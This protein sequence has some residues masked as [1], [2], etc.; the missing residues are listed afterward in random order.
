VAQ[1]NQAA[2]NQQ[3]QRGN[4]QQAQSAQQLQVAL[5]AQNAQSPQQ[6]RQT[7]AALNQQAQL[8]QRKPPSA[9]QSAAVQLQ[10]TQQAQ[11]AQ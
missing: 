1:Q 6:A 3:I 11:A 7:Q 9:A 2:L 8:E 5:Q 10:N 4:F